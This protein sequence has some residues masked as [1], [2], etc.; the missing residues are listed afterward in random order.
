V[1]RR[2]VP[3][4]GTCLLTL[5]PA[6]LLP[7]GDFVENGLPRSTAVRLTEIELREPDV[8]KFTALARGGRRPASQRPPRVSWTGA[9][10][11][12]SSAG[13]AVSA[14]SCGSS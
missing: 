13:R 10:A 2:A 12:A 4:D 9:L 11:T 1:L 6:T 8:N 3:F 7:T 5:D 14:T